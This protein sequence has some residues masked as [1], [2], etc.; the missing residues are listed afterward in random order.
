MLK[1]YGQSARLVAGNTTIYELSGQGALADVDR[2]IDLMHL[3]LNYVRA[4]GTSIKIGATTTFSELAKS[5]I[6]D[7]PEF[8]GLKETARKLTPPQIRNM[9]TIGGA[10]CSGIP[11]YDM[12]TTVLAQGARMK[13][14]SSEGEKIIDADEFFIDYF[15]TA[16]T[17]EAMLT[18]LEFQGT[19]NTGTAFVKLGRA[20]ADF[21]VVNAATKITLDPSRKRVQNARIAMGAVAS[22]PV[23]AKSAEEALE[24]EETTQTTIIQ[25]AK[26]A[27][28]L[29]PT[30]SVHASSAYKKRVI[31]ILVRDALI[32]SVERTGG[33]ILQK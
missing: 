11:F 17:P 28:N 22:T 13:I 30:S 5:P 29:E 9:G 6:L 1:E 12:P 32:A 2:L 15:V 23:R 31:P 7:R 24:G 8:F 33:K 3:G 20:S 4:D 25:A 14:L 10:V 19:P 27:A 16:L 18:E 21:A 26:E